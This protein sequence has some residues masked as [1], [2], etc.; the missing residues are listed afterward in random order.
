MDIVWQDLWKP[1]NPE[2]TR[3]SGI[4]PRAEE[5]M[6]LQDG[7]AQNVCTAAFPGTTQVSA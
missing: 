3:Y 1:V 5:E 4:V 7:D 2:R 6:P